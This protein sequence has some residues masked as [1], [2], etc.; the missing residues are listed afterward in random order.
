MGIL[1]ALF[2]IQ[3][4]GTGQVGRYFGPVTVLW[5]VTLAV[6]GWRA[7]CVRPRCCG[8][9]T[10]LRPR[11]CARE[12]EAGLHPAV[13]GVPGPHRGEALYADMGH[14]GARPV[15]LAWYGLVW[16]SLV[17]NYFGQGAL[18]LR[19]PVAIENPFYLLAPDW[20]LLPLVG[21]ATL[22]TVIASPGD[23]HRR[24]P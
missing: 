11:L 18:V 16:P 19:S 6:L 21:L 3:K 24:I 14:F 10:P 7:S 9:S 1:V 8:P 5:F 23:H 13:G 2:M 12:P 15:R 4:H 20:F 22:A 17:L